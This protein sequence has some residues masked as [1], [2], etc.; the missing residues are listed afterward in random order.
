MP[1]Y[2]RYAFISNDDLLA[3]RWQATLDALLAQPAPPER[4]RVDG[5]EVVAGRLLDLFE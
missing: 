5:A 1:R 3:G 2:F 4:P